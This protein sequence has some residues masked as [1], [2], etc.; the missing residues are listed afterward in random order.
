MD[1]YPGVQGDHALSVCQQRV[2]V[3][4]TDVGQ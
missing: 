3:E 1:N 4:L 2:D